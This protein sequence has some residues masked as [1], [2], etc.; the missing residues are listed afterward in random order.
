MKT[1]LKVTFDMS[2]DTVTGKCETQVAFAL[3][4]HP[5]VRITDNLKKMT[6]GEIKMIC[7]VMDAAGAHLFSPD[8]QAHAMSAA[9]GSGSGGK[10]CPKCYTKGRPRSGADFAGQMRCPNCMYVWRWVADNGY[11]HLP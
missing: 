11:G 3:P 10:L 5:D 2:F 4:D 1:K 6:I 7:G 8:D 9:S